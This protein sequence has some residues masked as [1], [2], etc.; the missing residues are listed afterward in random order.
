MVIFYVNKIT[1]IRDI[2]PKKILRSHPHNV[3]KC[4]CFNFTKFSMNFIT[5]KLANWISCQLCLQSCHI[6]LYESLLFV[7]LSCNLQ[8]CYT[9][10]IFYHLKMSSKPSFSGTGS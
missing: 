3:K 7:R 4:Q 2:T 1:Q 9:L 8:S 6:S 10:E 5:S